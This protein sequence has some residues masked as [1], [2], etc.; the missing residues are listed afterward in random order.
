MTK[1]KGVQNQQAQAQP[2]VAMGRA[3]KAA[4][5]G[6]DTLAWMATFL[7]SKTQ[8]SLVTTCRGIRRLGPAVES[9]ARADLK[10]K[11][12]IFFASPHA[13]RIFPPKFKILVCGLIRQLTLNN[14]TEIQDKIK[15][16]IFNQLYFFSRGEIHL[17]RE[18][19]IQAPASVKNSFLRSLKAEEA[20]WKIREFGD[21]QHAGRLIGH[22]LK[23]GDIYQALA[24][25]NKEEK[26]LDRG[27]ALVNI[28]LNLANQGQCD[29]AIKVAKRIPL[30]RLKNRVL[31]AACRAW[32]KEERFDEVI[33]LASTLHPQEVRDRVTLDISEAL[34]YHTQYDRAVDLAFSIQSREFKE[35]TFVKIVQQL[36]AHQKFQL[37]IDLIREIKGRRLKHAAITVVCEGLIKAKQFDAAR[38]LAHRIRNDADRHSLLA[39]IASAQAEC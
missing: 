2:E 28:G 3:C 30:N 38:G 22:F 1:I 18:E 27:R 36:V 23:R 7:P 33:Q 4:L 35:L 12:D 31:E 25:A 6:R 5:F 11:M 20:S 16:A 19:L 17:L 32:I 9:Q 39:Q 29:L 14:T 8:A 34:A 21:G 24:V 15:A 37:A 10:K 13:Q 26:V